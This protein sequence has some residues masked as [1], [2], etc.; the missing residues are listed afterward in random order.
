M[1]IPPPSAGDPFQGAAALDRALRSPGADS[2]TPSDS[3]PLESGPDVVVT[4]SKPSAA[5]AT[6]NASG[7]LSGSPSL[8]G[9]GANAPDSMAKAAESGGDDDAA[10]DATPASTSASSPD[11]SVD[12]D[13]EATAAA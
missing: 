12:V 9:M 2:D 10:S 11:A 3:T 8:G 1:M 5:P 13:E 7:K 6:Y 4:L